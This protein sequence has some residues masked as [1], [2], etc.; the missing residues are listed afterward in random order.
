MPVLIDRNDSWSGNPRLNRHTNQP[1][2]EFIYRMAYE[3]GRHIIGYEIQKVLAVIDW[4]ETKD[5]NQPVG[6]FG[7]G[8]GGIV[9]LYAGA[10]D[11]RARVAVVRESAITREASVWEEPIER[12]IWS[13]LPEFRDE[14][15]ATCLGA[16]SGWSSSTRSPK[17]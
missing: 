12:S 2:R 16:G 10:L 8:E 5:N 7:Y 17:V 6:L 14:I 15:C 9:A 13:A 4:F 11:A 1:H 3:M